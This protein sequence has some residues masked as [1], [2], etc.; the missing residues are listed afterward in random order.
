MAALINASSPLVT[1]THNNTGRACHP[2]VIDFLIEHGKETWGGYRY[3]MAMTPLEN[4]ENAMEDP[5]ILCSNDNFTWL[6]PAGITN[7]LD[8]APGGSSYHSDTDMIYNP[9]T[10]ELWIYYRKRTDT[11]LEFKLIKIGEDMSAGT[12]AVIFSRVISSG[13]KV[14]CSPAV[15]RESSTSWHL[16]SVA[17]S[18]DNLS[19]YIYHYTSLDGENWNLNEGAFDAG[20]QCL[21]SDGN[22]PVGSLTGIIGFCWHLSCKPN[23]RERRIEFIIHINGNQQRLLWFYAPMSKPQLFLTPFANIN[24]HILVKSPNSAAWDGGVLYRASFVIEEDFNNNRYIHHVW[25]GGADI[26][27]TYFHIGYTY[28]DIMSGFIGKGWW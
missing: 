17:A 22:D 12:P 27:N 7:P 14:L 6:V 13:D 24:Q 23:Y 15:W 5:N 26:V 10:N 16:W 20:Q 3:W 2:S 1:P 11:G 18:S 9:T 21:N 4:N 19:N 25:Y 28:G 8:D